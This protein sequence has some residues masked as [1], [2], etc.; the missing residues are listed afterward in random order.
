MITHSNNHG[1]ALAIGDPRRSA[2]YLQVGMEERVEQPGRIFMMLQSACIGAVTGFYLEKNVSCFEVTLM[3]L[4]SHRGWNAP[5]SST[6]PMAPFI[7]PA[8]SPLTLCSFSFSW[9]VSQLTIRPSKDPRR[10][11][12]TAVQAVTGWE[13]EREKETEGRYVQYSSTSLMILYSG[14]CC[15]ITVFS[16]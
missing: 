3:F 10:L 8:F 12:S 5:L 1:G 15:V 6:S 14:L 7:S 13:T 16:K 2:I 9:W 4:S 11:S